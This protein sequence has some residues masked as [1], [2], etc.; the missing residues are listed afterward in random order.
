MSLFAL[1]SIQAGP[2]TSLPQRSACGEDFGTLKYLL[3]G[4]LLDYSLHG[5]RTFPS[6]SLGAL[7]ECLNM[8]NY[9]LP[10]SRP[11]HCG[12]LVMYSLS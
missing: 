8:W 9:T 6:P 2:V 7:I 3:D 5:W 4:I 12:K 10:L 11:G 1:F